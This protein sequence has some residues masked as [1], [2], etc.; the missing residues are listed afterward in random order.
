MS[1]ERLIRMMLRNR[2]YMKKMHE[3]KQADQ[4][5]IAYI[6][7]LNIPNGALV[8]ERSLQEKASE[9]I[10]KFMEHTEESHIKAVYWMNIYFAL[11][12]LRLKLIGVMKDIFLKSSQK[13]REYLKE[14]IAYRCRTQQEKYVQNSLRYLQQELELI[15]GQQDENKRRE[16]VL[17]EEWETFS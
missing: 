13:Q 6:Y 16:I 2:D 5:V 17:P 12:A 7:T 4:L 15:C 1:L 11:Y 9:V 3:R 10:G 8:K 14:E